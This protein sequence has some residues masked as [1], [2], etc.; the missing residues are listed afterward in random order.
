[1]TNLSLYDTYDEIINKIQQM[2]LY[3]NKNYPKDNIFTLYL[4]NGDK[5]RYSID[6]NKISH[7]LGI[8]LDYLANMQ[9][10]KRE[11]SKEML[12]KFLKSNYSVYVKM[13]N[14]KF[15]F[16]NLFSSHIEHKLDVFKDQLESPSPNNIYFICK[17]DRSKNYDTGEVDVYTSDYYI[18]R[19]L[20]NDDI[21][22]LGL[23]KNDNN[24]S[25]SVQ[26][27]RVIKKGDLQLEELIKFVSKQEITYATTLQ[28]E[29]HFT[30][31]NKKQYLNFREKLDILQRITNIANQAD[32]K[33]NTTKAHLFDVVGLSKNKKSHEY[34]KL[35]LSQLTVAMLKGNAFDL[36]K[37]ERLSSLLDDETKQLIEVYNN[38]I[39]GNLNDKFP[40]PKQ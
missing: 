3:Y 29:N 27:S 24:D 5:I 19:K 34:N 33:P 17:Y 28:V 11:S 12:N 21:I 10:I 14:G 18:V 20:D 22:L 36:P 4:A 25:Y 6:E 2:V 16:S 13:T 38:S 32:A 30:K 8:N 15:N 39:K 1:M 23:V 26:T 40:Y 9:I 37:D 31:L 7:L 35:I